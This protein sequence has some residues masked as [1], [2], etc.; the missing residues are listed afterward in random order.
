MIVLDPDQEAAVERMVN[1][2]TRAALNASQYGTGKTVVTVEVAKRL[3]A[4]VILIACPL[5]TKYS[6]EAT[7]IGQV[8][9]AVVKHINNTKAGK[10]AL[11]DL[12]AGVEGWYIIGREY[13]YSKREAI[14]RI[15]HN[16]D[17]MAYDECAK[18]A[19][20]GSAGWKKL[21]KNMKPGYKMALSATPYGNKF[22]NIHTIVQ[23]LWWK[24][25]GYYGYWNFVADWCETREDFFGGT[26]VVGE[27]NPGEYVD[28]LPC[29]V[30]LTKD[31]GEPI[32]E[33]IVIHLSP[34]ER[35]MYEKLK[36]DLIVWI[37]EH[38]LI[39]KFPFTKRMRLRQMTLGELTI[40]PDTEEIYY[41]FDMKSTKFDTLLSIV[42]EYPEEPML[43]L[44][45]SAKYA[46]VVAERMLAA[47]LRVLPWTGSIS[48]AQRHEVKR[49]F[50]EGE[51]D[52]IVATI[53]SIG[54]GV[55]GLQHRSRFMVWLSRSDDNQL[56]MQAFR[57]LYRRGQK[58]QVISLDIAAVDTY[59]NGQLDNLI[60]QALNQNAI[61][62]GK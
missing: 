24:L 56:N 47:G 8:P 43:I 23:W 31:F 60:V 20:W 54:E 22:G 14:T 25:D 28:H 5:F 40:D 29:Y 52:Y 41:P 36:R 19:N 58:H 34:K 61:L 7:I 57:R 46:H 35:A 39:V 13:L 17:F 62:K 59:D 32:E 55:D 44:T 50:I 9:D 27:K 18:W 30:R 48:E 45:D 10:E 11:D 42:N 53:Q 3:G 2:P 38:P 6:W 16:I 51:I 49:M 12:L 4:G 26:L 37:E 33:T 1:E 15:S 21:M